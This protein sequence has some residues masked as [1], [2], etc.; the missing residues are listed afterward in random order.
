MNMDLSNYKEL[1]KPELNN[2]IVNIRLR[3]SGLI[4]AIR[5]SVPEIQPALKSFLGSISSNGSY[6][7]RTVQDRKY[8]CQADGTLSE[9]PLPLNEAGKKAEQTVKQQLSPH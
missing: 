8:T 5:S 1:T 9:H 3:S 2:R 7:P 6:V 4:S